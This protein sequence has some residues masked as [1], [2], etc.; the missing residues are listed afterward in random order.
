MAT[1]WV[2][3]GAQLA[4]ACGTLTL[5][6]VTAWM[7]RRT[8]EVAKKTSDLVESSLREAKA[9]ETL[10]AEARTDRQLAWRPQLELAFFSQAI[11]KFQFQ[12]RN[13]GGGP[14]LQVVCVARQSDNVNTWSIV[15]AGDIRPNDPVKQVGGG[16]WKDG[17]NHNSLFEEM[18]GAQEGDIVTVVLL[19]SDVLGR[20]SRFGYAITDKAGGSFSKPL[21]AEVSV[22]DEDHPQHT[23]WAADPLVW[24]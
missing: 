9:T 16:A 20:R 1:N 14:A 5:A 19:C 23:G 11:D 6:G 15:R 13:T 3:V 4:V 12:V 18:P 10:A 17:G 24:G 8:H 2:D 21:P 7:A 22:L